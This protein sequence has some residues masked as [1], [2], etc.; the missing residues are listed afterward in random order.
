MITSEEFN[1]IDLRAGTIVQSDIF[2]EARQLSLKFWID[3]GPEI[4]I[5]KASAQIAEHYH[6]GDLIGRQVVCVFNFPAG[7]IAGFPDDERRVTNVQ[8]SESTL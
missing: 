2:P 1:K 7:R 4:G 8:H 5:K 6:P 3:L